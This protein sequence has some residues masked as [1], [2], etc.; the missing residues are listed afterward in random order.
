M[1][2]QASLAQFRDRFPELSEYSD[3]DVELALSDAVLFHSATTR[4]QLWAAAH[5]LTVGEKRELQR[6]R[7][8]P[9]EANYYR[10][11]TEIG[12]SFWAATR[13]GRRFR[14]WESTLEAGFSIH[15]S[16]AGSDD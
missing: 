16:P 7:T 1:A 15:V 6:H 3:S 13:Y 9:I 4:G 5:I 14:V 11:G 12:D 8:G 10:F 2:V